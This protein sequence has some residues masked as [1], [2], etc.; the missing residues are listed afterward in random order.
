MDLC[1]FEVWIDGGLD[2]DEVP[3]AREAIQELPKIRKHYDA[4]A[5]IG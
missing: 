4:A 5:V 2:G 1:S 3:V